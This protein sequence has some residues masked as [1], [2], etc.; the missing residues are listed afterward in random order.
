M[1]RSSSS[2]R[3]DC[4]LRKMRP[5]PAAAAVVAIIALQP[6]AAAPTTIPADD[7]RVVTVGRVSGSRSCRPTFEPGDGSVRLTW[8][9][10]GVRVAH[11]G[12]Y[13]RG[14][15]ALATGVGGS[16]R[17]KVRR[18]TAWARIR[19]TLRAKREVMCRATRS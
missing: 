9:G 1:D 16:G 18:G 10:A 3:S 6:A 4:P 14:V 11:S 8:V 13:L 19:R 2:R 5:F 15:F 7:P 17:V 12:T